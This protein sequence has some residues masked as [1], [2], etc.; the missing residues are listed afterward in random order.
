MT[1]HEGQENDKRILKAAL[2]GH[3]FVDHLR[4]HLRKETRNPHLDEFSEALGMPNSTTVDGVKIPVSFQVTLFSIPDARL[5][6]SSDMSRLLDFVKQERPDLVAV[7]I[8][9]HD[10]ASLCPEDTGANPTSWSKGHMDVL[11]AKIQEFHQHALQY[12]AAVVFCKVAMRWEYKDDL[13]QDKFLTRREYYNTALTALAESEPKMLARG[14]YK[15]FCPE[16]C[17]DGIHLTSLKGLEHYRK[18]IR[19]TFAILA[20]NVIFKGKFDKDLII[21][22][23]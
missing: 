1:K 6:S 9:T 3:S 4:N 2:I 11:L 13:Q 12:S 19:G 22:W 23:Y 15:E 18:F 7:E 10:L 14:T 16:W 20:R 5:V 21:L 17:S 8:G